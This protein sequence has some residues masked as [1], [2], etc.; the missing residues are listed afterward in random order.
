MKK[1][2]LLC[3]ILLLSITSYSQV[4]LGL[5]FAPGFSFNRFTGEDQNGYSS[6]KK[7]GIG[8]RFIAGPEVY[9]LMGDNAA[10]VTGIWFSSRRVGLKYHTPFGDV[11]ETYNLQYVSLPLY[12]K[13]YTNEVAT[14]MKV[15]FNVGGTFDVKVKDNNIKTNLATP[16]ITKWKP[17]DA[18][19]TLGTGI[20][21]QMGESTYLLAGISYNRGLVNTIGNKTKFTDING[22]N[23]D[24]K[25]KV[26]TDLLLLDIG[27]RF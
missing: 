27:L 15:Y 17:I 12:L 13:L 5:K 7:N 11:K 6:Y 20:Q 9:F 24:P 25:I 1:A 23:V 18:M 16:S 3:C 26:N 2:F 8:L 22:N 4:K 14:D 19:I 21:L 10:L